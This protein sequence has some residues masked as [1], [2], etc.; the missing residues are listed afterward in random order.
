MRAQRSRDDHGRRQEGKATWID[1]KRSRVG[2]DRAAL[3]GLVHDLYAASR[4]NQAFLHARFG[5]ADDALQ[6][7]QA[8]IS[9][10]VCP[11][12]L[13]HQDISVAKAKKAIS[14]YQKAIGRPEGLAELAV[15][16]CEECAA[17]LRLGFLDDAGYHAAL[18]RMFDQALRHMA[19]LPADQ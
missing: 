19:D 16:Y 7:Y 2:F 11:D 13:K 1:L 8:T 5:L 12:V 15:F 10:W 4:A 6:P 14:D 9:R 17:F 18:V 3:L